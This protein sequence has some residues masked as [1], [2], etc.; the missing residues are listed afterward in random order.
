MGESGRLMEAGLIGLTQ[1]VGVVTRRSVLL[2]SLNKTIGKV[3]DHVY[4][5]RNRFTIDDQCEN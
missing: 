2:P 4:L 1:R 3:A 5:G